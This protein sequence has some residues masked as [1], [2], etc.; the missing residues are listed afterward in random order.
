MEVFRHTL[1][2]DGPSD[3]NLVPILNWVLR[4]RCNLQ[5][6]EGVR[7]E[8]WRLPKPPRTLQDKLQC[9][10]ELY[11]CNLLFVHRDAE[12]QPPA[13]RHEEIRRAVENLAGTGITTPAVAVVPV[14][15]LEAWLLLDERSIRYAAGNPNGSQP[16][17]LP[18]PNRVE[19]CPDPKDELRRALRAAC[20]LHGRRL[21]KFDDS[22]AFWRITDYLQNFTTLRQLPAFCQLEEAVLRLNESNYASGFYGLV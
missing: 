14:R 1:V 9:A 16:L 10:L 6:T 20:G 3:A 18:Y 5:L 19:D 22:R 7:A 13:D 8:F 17:H 2:G 12:R 11:P 15:M 4:E 21:K